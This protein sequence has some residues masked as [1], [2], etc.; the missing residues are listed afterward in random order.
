[1]DNMP[2]ITRTAG[3]NMDCVDLPPAAWSMLGVDPGLAMM[4]QPKVDS[5]NDTALNNSGMLSPKNPKPVHPT[6]NLLN[7]GIPQSYLEI[8]LPSQDETAINTKLGSLLAGGNT[9]IFLGMK[10]G[11]TMIDPA[12]R[13]IYQE[14]IAAGR[15]PATLAGRPYDYDREDTMKVIV[16]MTDGMHVSSTYANPAFISGP[17]PIYRGEDGNYAIHHPGWSGPNKFFVSHLSPGAHAGATAAGWR[18][19]PLWPGSGVVTRLDWGQVWATLPVQW[20][21]LQLYGRPLSNNASQSAVSSAANSQRNALFLSYNPSTMDSD[22]LATCAAAKA[23]NVTIFSVAFMA[24]AHA[25]TL[26]RTCATSTAHFY[27]PVGS[28]IG[29]AFDSIANTINVLR[30]TQ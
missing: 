7:C 29:D 28:E 5:S 27:A 6:V 21:T 13:P 30:L 16:L 12:M 17:S 26:L 10:W 2:G 15:M 4:Q 24:P 19:T 23:E 20:V 8:S 11:L 22:L 3:L 25:Q 9:S 14:A 18:P 1:M